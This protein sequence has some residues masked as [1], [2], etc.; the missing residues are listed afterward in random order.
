MQ[1]ET[2]SLVW[3]M[4]L[5]R[6]GRVQTLEVANYVCHQSM[7]WGET[8]ASDLNIH[9]TSQILLLSLWLVRLDVTS[10]KPGFLGQV[11][12]TLL[13]SIPCPVSAESDS[14]A[15]AH[16]ENMRDVR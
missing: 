3:G 12:C 7:L 5:L 1:R 6:L 15:E 13:V 14:L 8:R 10:R 2:R 4:F 11:P 9:F 16:Q